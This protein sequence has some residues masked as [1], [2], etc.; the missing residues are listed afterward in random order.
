[1]PIT[2]DF[3]SFNKSN[4]DKSP[5]QSGVYALYRNKTLTYIGKASNSVRSRL[6]DH[7]AGRD[8][9]CTKSSTEYKRELTS[10]P[11]TR[12]KQLLQ[13]YVQQNG[14]LPLCNDVMP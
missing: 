1:M 8:G 10:S 7:Y 12:E 14:K 4:V 9:Q 2:G 6:Q 11:A 13:E 3:Y 5:A